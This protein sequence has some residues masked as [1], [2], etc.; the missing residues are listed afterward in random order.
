MRAITPTHRLIWQSSVLG[1]VPVH[2]CA[3]ECV[4]IDFLGDIWHWIETFLI[5][6]TWKGCFWYLVGRGHALMHAKLLQSCLTL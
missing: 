6:T 2:V 1:H 3:H 5:V 4:C